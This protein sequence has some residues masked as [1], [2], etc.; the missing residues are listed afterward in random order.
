MDDL[1][2]YLDGDRDGMTVLACCLNAAMARDPHARERYR[3]IWGM[4]WSPIGT[5]H[6]IH[7]G[8]STTAKTVR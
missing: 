3:A 1:A 7:D 4:D 5:G 8:S 6:E 2:I